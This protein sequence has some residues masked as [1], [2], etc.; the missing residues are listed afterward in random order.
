[1]PWPFDSDDPQH[2]DPDDVVQRDQFGDQNFADDLIQENGPLVGGQNFDGAR[3]LVEEALGD[4]DGPRPDDARRRDPNFERGALEIPWVDWDPE[5]VF[6][7]IDRRAA[8]DFGPKTAIIFDNDQSWGNG[9]DWF[10]VDRL[11]YQERAVWPAY[12]NESAVPNRPPEFLTPNQDIGR[13]R[14]ASTSRDLGVH[15]LR[16]GERFFDHPPYHDLRDLP[17]A[18]AA[19]LMT[20]AKF[21]LGQQRFDLMIKAS[22]FVEHYG[23]AYGI[24]LNEIASYGLAQF[25]D[26][27]FDADGDGDLDANISQYRRFR[28]ALAAIYG[29]GVGDSPDPLAPAR[30]FVDH[31]TEV[32]LLLTKEEIASLGVIDTTPFGLVRPV[33]NYTLLDYEQVLESVVKPSFHTHVIPNIYVL[34]SE[35]TNPEGDAPDEWFSLIGHPE[36]DFKQFVTVG[37]LIQGVRPRPNHENLPGHIPYSQKNYF[38]RWTNAID[39]LAP[40]NSQHEDA[41]IARSEQSFMLAAFNFRNIIIPPDQ[42]GFIKDANDQKKAYPMFNEIQFQT[43]Q[44]KDFANLFIQNHLSNL[45]MR[46][47]IYADLERYNTYIRS[48]SGAYPHNPASVGI[49]GWFSTNAVLNP[50]GLETTDISDYWEDIDTDAELREEELEF[51]DDPA[52]IMIGAPGSNE[53]LFENIA[54]G[55]M[56][57]LKEQFR[58]KL[59]EICGESMRFYSEMTSGPRFALSPRAPILAR[60][61]T[62]FYKIEKRLNGQIVQE[63]YV[64]NNNVPKEGDLDIFKYVDTQIL[65]GKLSNTDELNSYDYRIYA[66][67]LV[68]GSRY[69]RYA[70]SVPALPA[71]VDE[72]QGADPSCTGMGYYDWAPGAPGRPRTVAEHQERCGI[73]PPWNPSRDE[74]PAVFH[75]GW[76]Y[77]E[78]WR[79]SWQHFFPLPEEGPKARHTRTDV[80]AEV[81]AARRRLAVREH[82]GSLRLDTGSPTGSPRPTEAGLIA[83]IRALDAAILLGSDPENIRRFFIAI[84]PRGIPPED[85]HGHGGFGGG[86]GGDVDPNW[87]EYRALWDDYVNTLNATL[88]FARLH[89][90]K[91]SNPGPIGQ[92]LGSPHHFPS[93]VRMSALPNDPIVSYLNETPN[94]PPWGPARPLGGHLGWRRGHN[95][96]ETIQGDLADI[97]DNFLQTLEQIQALPAR[98]RIPAEQPQ[99]RERVPR[100]E[101][102]PAAV[103]G[104]PFLPPMDAEVGMYNDSGNEDL[105]GTLQIKIKCMSYVVPSLKLIQVPIFEASDVAIFSK[106]PA[107]PDIS[108][109]PYRAI[110]NQALILMNEQAST[111]RAQAPIYIENED[112]SVHL[113]VLR[114][115]YLND[116]ID[117]DPGIP[118]P[119]DIPIVFGNDDLPRA[120]E[121]YRVDSPPE[122]YADFA[123]NLHHIAS[124]VDE[125]GKPVVSSASLVDA[126]IPN[127]KY[128]YTFRIRDA[129]D[130]PSNPTPIYQVEL[131][132]DGSA[133]FMLF[134]IY[135]FPE[136]PLNLTKNV[137]RYLK[138]GPALAQSLV[139]M[140]R[141]GLLDE[142]GEPSATAKDKT[143]HL[144]IPSRQVWGRKY[145]F[146]L[147]SKKTGRKI[148]INID[149]KVNQLAE[150]DVGAGPG[151]DPVNDPVPLLDPLIPAMPVPPPGFDWPAPGSP[152]PPGGPPIP[153]LPAGPPGGPWNLPAPPTGFGPPPPDKCTEHAD[154]PRGHICVN[155]EC[156][157]G[158]I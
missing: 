71:P 38:C 98:E 119:L 128:Y 150:P 143:I 60:S 46:E 99:P 158:P 85:P 90:K 35:L 61:E 133:V 83:Q 123:G 76:E 129:H 68:I 26:G 134:E 48:F 22:E 148:D 86:G 101:I 84:D 10:S 120:Y 47:G 67:Q 93:F 124:L 74:D 37:N 106:P 144:G 116:W 43:D 79:M 78:D 1:M 24:T 63:F 141:S 59:T 104:P 82:E 149:F 112:L 115:Q 110:D 27:H 140:P 30:E 49:P 81:L 100:D 19:E 117:V 44:R 147:M 139:N 21:G 92:G 15:Y 152:F 113:S 87:V 75:V 131:V 108:I 66:G 3:G 36:R 111:H 41:S 52:A 107:T 29:L 64:P 2:G 91:E 53:E 50:I 136:T 102:E 69:N 155:G 154:C 135:E 13:G 80:V 157:P 5:E 145:K 138:L 70:L 39:K 103:A 56:A 146:R 132:N 40:I 73:P 72:A 96:P 127:R 142:S 55:H 28:E 153:D 4:I 77:E 114:G 62:V 54:P 32:P 17:E 57:T 130:Q 65:Y 11:R 6:Q 109:A 34:A 8:G 20:E 42:L 105:N 51:R 23:D 95:V 88:M 121:V 18:R 31:A 12:F 33:Y 125:N 58:E 9:A 25:I 122:S 151:C 94:L 137:R 16:F 7:D 45:I 89:Y 156:V 97:R 126:L 14:E 118:E